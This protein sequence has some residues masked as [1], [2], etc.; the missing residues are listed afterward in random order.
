MILVSTTPSRWREFGFA[1]H[2]VQRAIEP[3][4]SLKHAPCNWNGIA[5]AA[6]GKCQNAVTKRPE[7]G[8]S[9]HAYASSGRLNLALPYYWGNPAR[10]ILS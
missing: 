6:R 4:F 1:L 10:I 3:H 9:W 2:Q 5:R 8:P 7:S